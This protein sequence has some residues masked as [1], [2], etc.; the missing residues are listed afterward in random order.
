MSLSCALGRLPGPALPG[1]LMCRAGCFEP[2]KEIIREVDDLFTVPK[3]AL[4]F[5]LALSQMKSPVLSMCSKPFLLPFFLPVKMCCSQS[6]PP[7]IEHF[8]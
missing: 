8:C 6:L 1:L 5:T 2:W 3:Q 4:N 7:D